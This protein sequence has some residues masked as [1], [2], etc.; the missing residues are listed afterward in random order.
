MLQIKFVIPA[1]CRFNRPRRSGAIFL[2]CHSGARSLLCH[3][4]RN[5]MERRIS[6]VTVL[7]SVNIEILHPEKASGFRMTIKVRYFHLFTCLKSVE[8]KN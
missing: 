7:F 5:E 6:D 8:T 1:G 4:E 2:T 3:S